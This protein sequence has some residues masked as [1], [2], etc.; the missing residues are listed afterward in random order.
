MLNIPVADVV[1]AF[2]N[3]FARSLSA[4]ISAV[5]FVSMSISSG[6]LGAGGSINPAPV[7]IW[8]TPGAVGKK[9]TELW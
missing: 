3:G 6:T 9:S 5:P 2:L 7:N 8:I 4:E 1:A